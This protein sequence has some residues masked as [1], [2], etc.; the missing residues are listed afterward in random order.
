MIDW[1]TVR[2]LANY[3]IAL[4]GSKE[5]AALA[6]IDQLVSEV[7][8][9]FDAK[10]GITGANPRKGVTHFK[11]DMA[12]ELGDVAGTALILMCYFSDDPEATLNECFEKFVNR[13]KEAFIRPRHKDITE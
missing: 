8:E 9:V 10:I 4:R 1:D 2:M 5:H 6:S 3:F 7:G 11:E 12:W 13:S